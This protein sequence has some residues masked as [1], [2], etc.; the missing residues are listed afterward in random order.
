M[1]LGFF[2]KEQIISKIKAFDCKNGDLIVLYMDIF[3]AKDNWDLEKVHETYDYIYSY[4]HKDYPD[5]VVLG[6]DVNL[7][8][9]INTFPLDKQEK[10]EVLSAYRKLHDLLHKLEYKYG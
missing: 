4:L 6:V 5:S 2:E 7:F 9:T 3:S 10:E 1:P 8:K